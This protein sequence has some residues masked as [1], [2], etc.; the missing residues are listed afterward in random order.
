MLSLCGPAHRPRTSISV[1]EPLLGQKDLILDVQKTLGSLQEFIRTRIR[2]SEIA[3]E[4]G[5]VSNQQEILKELQA[6]ARSLGLW[7][8]A[9][10]RDSGLNNRQLVGI[11]EQVGA[12]PRLGPAAINSGA[13]DYPNIIMLDAVATA[14]QREKILQPLLEGRVTSAFAMTE[15]DVASSDA[16][17]IETKIRVDEDSATISG[18]KWYIT[19]ATRKNCEWLFVLGLS[20]KD[21][22]QHHQHTVVAVPTKSPGVTIKRSLPVMGYYGDQAEIELD[23]VVV[24]NENIIGLRGEGFKV[25]QTRLA[26]ARL[27]HAARTLGLA[28]RAYEMMLS[29]ARTRRIREQLLA[30][31]D[32]FRAGVA[33]S[34]MQLTQTR[35]LVEE[36]AR[37]L[38]T[39]ADP[40]AALQLTSQA[41]II[42]M[43]TGLDVIGRA[44]DAH[45]AAGLSDETPLASWWSD[46]RGLHIADGPEATHLSL[47]ARM[48]MARIEGRR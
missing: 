48:E 37:V 3:L 12:Y 24:P 27:H 40:R 7:N 19:G 6:E 13:P 33:E 28:R 14:A 15:P 34:K 45:G 2:P 23:G 26:A 46:V 16:N 41:K 10:A 44:I 35:L 17:N 11:S 31:L 21:A 29:R 39:T 43:R 9:F 38:D 42:A 25:G 18:H 5:E 32:M 20:D 8:V 4:N 47:I 22:P 30:D 36:T 1:V